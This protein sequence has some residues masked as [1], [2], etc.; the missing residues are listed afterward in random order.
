[1][2]AMVCEV[3][4]V[5]Y[6]TLPA[7]PAGNCVHYF[8]RAGRYS[9]KEEESALLRLTFIAALSVSALLAQTKPPEQS[10][11][12]FDTNLID[13][14]VDP[15]QNFYQFACGGWMKKNPIPPDQSRWGRFSELQERNR[16]ILHQI[17]EEAA[18]PDP[19]RDATTQKIGD[20]YAACMDIKAID[21][22][23]LKPLDP[24]L[25]K[26]RDMKSKSDLPGVVAYLHGRGVSGLFDFSSGADFKDSKMNIAQLDQ[27]GLGLPDRDYYLKTDPKSVE[28]RQKYLAHV[29]RMFELA[30]YTPDKA[31]AAADTVMRVET[32]LA[33]AS[34]DRV[35]QRDPEKVYHKLTKQEL[36][37]LGQGF[38]WNAYFR[39]SGAPAFASLNVSWPDFIKG[40][41]A[42]VQST[43]LEDWKT[44]LTW[45]LL[46]S[47]A[48]ILPTPF[49]EENFDFYGKTLTGA[50]E[51][52]ARWKRCADFVDSQ[53][54]EAL[55]KKY[56]EL[57]F[58]A[59]G[60]ARTLEMVQQ[61][62]KAL[63][64]DIQ[65]LSWMSPATKQQAL[66]KLHAITNKIGY[67]NKWRDY[68]SLT[69]KRDD[70][71]GNDDRASEFETNRQLRKIGKAVDPSEWEMTPPTVN[72]YYDPLTNSINFPAGILQPPFFDKL[73][74][75]AVNFGGIGM[76]IG[77]ELTHGFD[78][79][80]RQF[81]AQGNL[82]DW[83]TPEDA[84]RFNERV[85]CIDKEYSGFTVAPD[86]HV[87]GKLT[88]GEN[89]ADNGG[90]RVSLKALH[91]T[92]AGK[93]P[94][95][96]INGFTP[97]QR[98][99]LAFAQ[100]WC[101]N[102]R[103]EAQRLQVQTDPHSPPEFRVNGV[104]QNMPEFQKAF[105]CKAGAPMVSADA[106]HVW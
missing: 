16:E 99:F 69:I 30:G 103:P 29:Q 89:T 1:M 62:E 93:P 42:E 24:A 52:R 48:R 63:G 44:Y 64:E 21:A 6:N 87:N 32:S 9:G 3:T 76:V 59:E 86:V 43:P 26:I 27:G 82:H 39:D 94:Q 104:V 105:S 71:L 33:K 91:N 10:P 73:I 66:V 83:W 22:K 92:E 46:H 51:M 70:A 28:I 54:G 25:S 19:N 78:D 37:A 50:T 45:H 56:V 8:R 88:L 80:G 106:C 98:F 38:S 49:T 85:A 60:K 72:A 79:E 36:D 57:T 31:K 68:S 58:G 67:P 2:L 74:D 40:M 77:H 23:G 14:S 11:L 55:G 84:K 7:H 101:A 20:Y 47:N 12:R 18:K 41:D 4:D 100:V 15:C 5:K 97:D 34:L 102:E 17:L 35:S 95:T 81:D 96:P 65:D 61:L 75:D 53:L 13:H 90:V